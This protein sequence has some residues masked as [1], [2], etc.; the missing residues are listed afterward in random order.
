MVFLPATF[1][2][3]LFSTDIIKYRDGDGHAIAGSYSE[4]AMFKWLQVSIPLTALT[5][6]F[7]LM[8]YKVLKYVEVVGGWRNS[9][10]ALMDW[11]LELR[12]FRSS[13]RRGPIIPIHRFNRG[14]PMGH[15]STRNAL[16]GP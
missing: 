10:I 2:S 8:T 11:I 7:S 6:V 16:V 13:S 3:T 5:L 14:I 15:V 1:V 9:I 4:A 12:I